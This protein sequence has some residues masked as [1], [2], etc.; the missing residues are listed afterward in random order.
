MHAN[1][2][3]MLA[4]ATRIAPSA[5]PSKLG[6]PK[7]ASLLILGDGFFSSLEVCPVP[8]KRTLHQLG[9]QNLGI[10]FTNL[11]FGCGGWSQVC[12]KII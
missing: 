9:I 6:S 3:E 10:C 4:A 5:L 1:A 12:R 7:C 8:L 11:F 2:A